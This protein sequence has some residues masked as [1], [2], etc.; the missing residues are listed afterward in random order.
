M[1][2]ATPLGLNWATGGSNKAKY[3]NMRPALRHPIACPSLRSF[4]DRPALPTD[5]FWA[6][7]E[8]VDEEETDH[9]L[10]HD[11]LANGVTSEALGHLPVRDFDI[12]VEVEILALDDEEQRLLRVGEVGRYKFQGR[13]KAERISS[14][15]ATQ[16]SSMS[17]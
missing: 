12:L 1:Q 6:D 15:L 9:E 14:A 4:T 16:L 8:D 7:A 2:R 3:A 11:G 13:P 5:E 10:K 17:I